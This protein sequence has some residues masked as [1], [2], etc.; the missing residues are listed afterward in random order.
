MAGQTRWWAGYRVLGQGHTC[1]TLNSRCSSAGSS[2]ASVPTSAILAREVVQ[3]L[4]EEAAPRGIR[5][6]SDRG[7]RVHRT[8]CLLRGTV[9]WQA[10][11]PEQLRCPPASSDASPC[12]ESAGPS[13]RGSR[14]AE[15]KL[16]RSVSATG[17]SRIHRVRLGVQVSPPLPE[18]RGDIDPGIEFDHQTD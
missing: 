18:V 4:A 9:S 1:L 17:G 5:P 11:S 2:A 13:G 8:T 6:G 7:R 15:T 14:N 12:V 10:A 3:C 16:R